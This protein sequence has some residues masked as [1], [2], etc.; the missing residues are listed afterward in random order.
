MAELAD[1]PDS[2]SG[3]ERSA[4]STPAPGT[5]LDGRRLLSIEIRQISKLGSPSS[6]YRR[7]IGLALVGLLCLGFALRGQEDRVEWQ[8]LDERWTLSFY[9]ENDLFYNTDHYYTNGTKLSWISSDLSDEFYEASQVPGLLQPIARLLPFVNEPGVQKN[10]VFS[11]GHNLY[12]PTDI[13]TTAYQ[14]DD[15]PY[16]AWLYLGMGL[17]NQTEHW[18]DTIELNL[19]VVGPWALGEE[20]QNFVHRTRGLQ[21]AEGWANQIRNEVVLNL[22]Y[23]RRWRWDLIGDGT[24]WGMDV[25][26]HAGAS[27]GNL[28]TYV[29]AGGGLRLGWN[30]PKDFG[31]AIIRLAGDTNA[32]AGRD[33]VRF[34]KNGAFGAHLFLIVDGRVMFRDLTL[35]GNTFK[36]SAHIERD[37]L[38]GDLTGGV[39]M[40]LGAWKFSYAAT[41]RAKTFKGGLQQT[42]GSFNISLTY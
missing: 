5:I 13:V 33:D 18:Q 14:P 12:T 39:A 26:G 23:E 32:P 15:R 36:D 3:S 41:I 42:F 2:K 21:T 16:A 17:H 28:F 29:N 31:A 25:L 38:T 34:R 35:D 7:Q 40:I 10:V 27:L 37:W 9:Y 22:V 8:P 20:V 1:A 24:G 30:L 11:L 19:G 4:G 6:I